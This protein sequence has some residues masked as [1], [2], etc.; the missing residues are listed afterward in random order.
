[1][2]ESLDKEKIG[3]EAPALTEEFKIPKIRNFEVHRYWTGTCY[4]QTRS[5][6][7][8]DLSLM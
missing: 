2:I 8:L 6:D 3:Q 5:M 1:V 4:Q 7:D